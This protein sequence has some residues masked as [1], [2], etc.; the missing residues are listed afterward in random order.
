MIARLLYAA[1]ALCVL[2]SRP[3]HAGT[4]PAAVPAAGA[5]APATVVVPA[6]PGGAAGGIAGAPADFAIPRIQR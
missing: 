3:E 2:G 1:V 6:C 4:A 5:A